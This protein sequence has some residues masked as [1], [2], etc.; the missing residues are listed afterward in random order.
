LR[1]S[2]RDAILLIMLA[3]AILLL[4]LQYNYMQVAIG[5]IAT[6]SAIAG[7]LKV[8]TSGPK[9]R[10]QLENDRQAIG[11]SRSGDIFDGWRIKFTFV[12][13][14]ER[15]GR[16]FDSLAKI[17]L[18]D[19]VRNVVPETVG[20]SP[21]GNQDFIVEPDRPVIGQVSLGIKPQTP[22][23][24]WN[25]HYVEAVKAGRLSVK[26]EIHWKYG[27]TAKR[28]VKVPPIIVLD[29]PLLREEK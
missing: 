18:S 19:E 29:A 4:G 17:V 3:V 16:V 27:D 22:G 8:H 20:F 21:G 28:N 1:I 26:I 23:P 9:I 14:G 10:L 6:L 15:I 12:N 11:Y 25:S 2:R 13:D 7:I 5:I 24:S